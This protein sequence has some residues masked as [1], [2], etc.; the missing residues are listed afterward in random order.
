[1][2]TINSWNNTITDAATTFNGGAVNIGSDATSNAINIGTVTARTVTIGNT[3]GASAL[4]LKCGTGNFSL[5]SA[6]GNL[7]TMAADGTMQEPLQPAFLAYL[8]ATVLNKTG[9]SGSYNLGTDALT[10]VFDQNGDFNVNGT[11]TAPV[12]GRYLFFMSAAVDGC[13]IASMI[14]ANIT[15]T[16]NSYVNRWST[17]ANSVA[18]YQTFAVIAYMTAGDTATAGVYTRGEAAN[19]DDIYGEAGANTCFGGYLLC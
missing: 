18:K 13:T 3:T 6:T 2:P 17:A 4:A 16:L 7:I 1:M 9:N 14:E 8:A 10:E 19:T 5:A 12:T 11:F 15:T